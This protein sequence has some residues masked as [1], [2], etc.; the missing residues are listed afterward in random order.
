MVSADRSAIRTQLT[1]QIHW[2][3]SQ[4]QKH[5]Q[6][7]QTQDSVLAWGALVALIAAT[8]LA[9][10][11]AIVNNP[12]VMGQWPHICGAV[13]GL[14]VVGGIC[15][16]IAQRRHFDQRLD[17]AEQCEGKLNSIL[18]ALE[19]QTLHWPEVVEEYRAVVEQYPTILKVNR[20]I[21]GRSQS[22]VSSTPR[23]L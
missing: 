13:G 19:T 6:R 17:E 20:R 12:D 22:K 14:N 16:M 21:G 7:L 11:A 5:T 23:S 15:E 2:H 10:V 1:H 4:A 9:F 3:C 8:V 18:I